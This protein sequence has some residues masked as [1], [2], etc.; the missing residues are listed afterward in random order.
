MG[1]TMIANQ[2]SALPEDSIQ[3][4]FDW[5]WLEMSEGGKEKERGDEEPMLPEFVSE[6][7]RQILEDVSE[8]DEVL[9]EE[10]IRCFGVEGV[11]DL[12]HYPNSDSTRFT[13]KSATSKLSLQE[14]DP[15]YHFTATR[16]GIA[17]QSDIP[18]SLLVKHGGS[19]E[20]LE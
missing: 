2:V 15:G 7:F 20:L 18:Q 13:L 19:L 8:F 16:E 5:V 1:S 17:I 9:T 3:Q 10:I 12:L 6:L 14:N 4:F 11:V